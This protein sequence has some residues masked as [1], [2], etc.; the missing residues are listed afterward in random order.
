VS[1][2]FIDRV[3]TTYPDKIITNEQGVGLAYVHLI[4]MARALN[5]CG[6]N[7]TCAQEKMDNVGPA[8]EI[9][10]RGFKNHVADFDILIDEFKDGQFVEVK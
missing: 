9:G 8:P 2:I 6:S 10:F 7:M 5:A 4:H 3:K 1:T